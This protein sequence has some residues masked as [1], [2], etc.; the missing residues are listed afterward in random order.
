MED[1]SATMKLCSNCQH[2]A[3][4]VLKAS[5]SPFLYYLS[6]LLFFC[7]VI[8]ELQTGCA[9][10]EEEEREER[11]A[12]RN[13]GGQRCRRDHVEEVEEEMERRGKGQAVKKRGIILAHFIVSRHNPHIVSHHNPSSSFCIFNVFS[14]HQRVFLGGDRPH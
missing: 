9:A 12:Q 4:E 5:S 2:C 11:E 10:R 7:W 13:R 8:Y 14:I 1:K 3:A 6:S